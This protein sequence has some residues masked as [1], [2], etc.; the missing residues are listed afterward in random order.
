MRST[1]IKH[2]AYE[3]YRCQVN[4]KNIVANIKLKNSN[5]GHCS[6]NNNLAHSYF[7]HYGDFFVRTT[8]SRCS[9]NFNKIA[10][11]FIELE[12]RSIAR[13]KISIRF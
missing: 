8:F 1:R 13:I 10:K 4:I 11:I 9:N 7:C 2:I 12:I 6:E 3:G 5:W